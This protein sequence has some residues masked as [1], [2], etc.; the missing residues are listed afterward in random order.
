MLKFGKDGY[1][2]CYDTPVSYDVEGYLDFKDVIEVLHEIRELPPA[3]EDDAK[4]MSHD[5][6]KFTQGMR[7]TKRT[8]EKTVETKDIRNMKKR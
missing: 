4:K 5:G 3:E 7:K 8:D 1:K 2:I 6:N